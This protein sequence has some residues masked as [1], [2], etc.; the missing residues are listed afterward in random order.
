MPKSS[1]T[2]EIV[3]LRRETVTLYLRGKTPLITRRLSE[4]AR[5]ELLM[6]SAPKSRGTRATT[7]KHDPIAEFRDSPYILEDESAPTLLALPAECFKNAISDIATDI[8]GVAKSVMRRHTYVHGDLVPIWGV[9][10]MKM[11]VVRS[12]NI[13]RTPDIRSRCAVKEWAAIINIEFSKPILNAS[14][15]VNLA[16]N[17]GFQGVGDWRQQKGAGNY[18]QWDIV[19]E[20]DPAFARIIKE[21]GRKAQ[22]AAMAS[23]QMYDRETRELFAWFEDAATKRGFEFSAPER[24]SARGNG[25]TRAKGSV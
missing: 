11:D 8:P 4:K 5:A 2:I 16:A 25:R 7:L 21:G 1:E 18:G 22:M 13:N 10:C 6:P 20:D 12:A 17:A 19:R 9:P 15:I 23:P 14:G 24:V 3:Q